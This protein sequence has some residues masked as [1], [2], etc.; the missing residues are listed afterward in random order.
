MNELDLWASLDSSSDGTALAGFLDKGGDIYFENPANG[1]TF[2]QLACDLGNERL[3]RLLIDRGFDPNH[4]PSSGSPA[5]FQALDL[6]LDSALQKGVSPEFKWVS[7]LVGQ[8]AILSV[9]QRDGM[10]LRGY[11]SEEY[12]ESFAAAFDRRFRE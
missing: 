2:L 4:V 11:C 10:S 7:L 1:W 6:D 8:G 12:G 3:I 9:Q 5:I